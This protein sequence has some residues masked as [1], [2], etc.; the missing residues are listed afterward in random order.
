L[1]SGTETGIKRI[2]L[3][4]GS[5]FAKDPP[6]S[7]PEAEPRLLKKTQL[8]ENIPSY[9]QAVGQ[10]S[11]YWP[12]ISA[13]ALTEV[14]SVPASRPLSLHLMTESGWRIGVAID[15]TA[16][17]GDGQPGFGNGTGQRAPGHFDLY[18][19]KLG[20]DLGPSAAENRVKRAC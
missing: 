4:R 20:S 5:A 14:R 10:E 2:V 7:S 18:T 6:R 12:V 17:K 19:E 13:D 8:K 16:H 11:N 9:L 1:H 3:H 15:V